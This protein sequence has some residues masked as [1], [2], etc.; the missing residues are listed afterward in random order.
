MNTRIMNVFARLRRRKREA[1]AGESAVT[2]RAARKL[3]LL[4]A[5]DLFRDLDDGQMAD[6]EQMTVMRQCKKGRLIY[7]AG[8]DG[9]ALFLL[10]EGKVNVYRVSPEG[11]KLITI[12]I[13]PGTLFGNMA[14]T[15]STLA[16]NFAEAVDDSVLCVMSRH[17][18]EQLIL[19]YPVIGVRLVSVLGDR[20]RDLEARFEEGLLRDMTARVAA[21]L[22]R[23]RESRGSDEI[24]AT[25]Q[26]LADGLGTYRETVT[27]TLGGIQ[28]R[29]YIELHR[30][31]VRILDAGALRE[32][33]SQSHVD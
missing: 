20:M 9:E 27:S 24:T 33:V 7:A 18:L 26:E 8:Q 1:E 23:L 5:S 25:H 16:D 2:T 6:V 13:A 10:K 12:V 15:G 11:R 3:G 17:D 32:I 29:G 28:S 4:G 19:R 31:R 30:G 22:L 21:A 14:F